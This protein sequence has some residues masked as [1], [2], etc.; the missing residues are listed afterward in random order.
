MLYGIASEAQSLVIIDPF[1]ES[2]ADANMVV[3]AQSG[4]GKSYFVKLMALRNLL[5]GIDFVVID[6]DNEY[7]AVCEVGRAVHV[8][9]VSLVGPAHKPSRRTPAR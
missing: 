3:C 1:D 2:L 5:S 8:R 9:P 6:P 7:R 4:K